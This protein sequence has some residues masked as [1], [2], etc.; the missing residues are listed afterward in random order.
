MLLYCAVLLAVSTKHEGKDIL[1]KGVLRLKS[2]M[3]SN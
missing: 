2:K 3:I 1:T